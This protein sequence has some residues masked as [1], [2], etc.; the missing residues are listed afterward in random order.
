MFVFIVIIFIVIIFIVMF[1]VI[2]GGRW[3]GKWLLYRPREKV[4]YVTPSNQIVMHGKVLGRS[5]WYFWIELGWA[6]DM[7]MYSMEAF[8]EGH[9]FVRD[10]IV[11]AQQ[12]E[13]WKQINKLEFL[14]RTGK[15]LDSTFKKQTI[16]I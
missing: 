5:R 4:L 1:I 9:E 13:D 8:M 2:E 14:L 7:A 6:I 16:I 3:L 15:S 12:E 11:N 10:M